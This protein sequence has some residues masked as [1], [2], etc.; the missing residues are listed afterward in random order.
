MNVSN[1]LMILFI[2]CKVANS[3]NKA[4][5]RQKEKTIL[6]YNN[7]FGFNE[8]KFQDRLCQLPNQTRNLS[9]WNLYIFIKCDIKCAYKL[10]AYRCLTLQESY[11][12]KINSVATEGC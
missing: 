3:Y 8:L 11:V 4:G 2:I 6:A 7:K 1:N 10:P 12:K 9:L 5:L